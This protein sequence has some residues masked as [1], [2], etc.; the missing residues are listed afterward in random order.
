MCPNSKACWLVCF[1]VSVL[2][3]FSNQ[4]R[5][6]LLQQTERS[7]QLE[8]QLLQQ[9]AQQIKAMHQQEDAATRQCMAAAAEASAA[10]QQVLADLR[11]VMSGEDAPSS[12]TDAAEP[13]AGASGSY[14][15][16]DGSNNAETAA[17]AAAAAGSGSPA[18][19]SNLTVSSTIG[20]ASTS[21]SS[22]EVNSW[23]I[24][25]S[26]PA[27]SAEQQQ[28]QQQDAAGRK[29]TGWLHTAVSTMI[30]NLQT[31]AA[32][33]VA[34]AE[35][36][37]ARQ[38]VA[39]QSDETQQNEWLRY[40]TS[41]PAAGNTHTLHEKAVAEAIVRIYIRALH[42]LE[43]A[44]T[45]ELQQRQGRPSSSHALG[46]AGLDAAAAAAG[47]GGGAGT[48][49]EAMM[50]HYSQQ[51]GQQRAWQ[52]YD[53]SLW[54]DPQVCCAAFLRSFM[55]LRFSLLLVTLVAVHT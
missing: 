10:L 20:A 48:L 51:Q 29:R 36:I 19:D 40:V 14:G 15:V 41:I 47:P 50:G 28:Q 27:E 25:T 37:A 17:D 55:L 2:S 34:R 53:A 6:Q 24:T 11:Q 54:K 8:L 26:A 5:K 45:H 12:N 30:G 9:E 16:H 32:E 46:S 22:S 1:Q 43:A 21:D 38:E 42:Q 33:A 49:F 4:L 23:S 52:V 3:Y 35:L 44:W 31:V 18:N 7:A 39:V 13:A